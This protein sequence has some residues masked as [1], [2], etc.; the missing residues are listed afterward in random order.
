MKLP[1]C[2]HHETALMITQHLFRWWLDAVGQKAFDW[3]IADQLLCRHMARQGTIYFFHNTT[4]NFQLRLRIKWWLEKH[5]PII[6]KLILTNHHWDTIEYNQLLLQFCQNSNAYITLKKM[7]LNYYFSWF[8]S[9]LL[10]WKMVPEYA[11]IMTNKTV[12]SVLFCGNALWPVVASCKAVVLKLMALIILPNQR[13][14]GNC[15]IVTVKVTG[16]LL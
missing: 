14:R 16:L 4:Y 11:S 13:R 1:S 7:H 9:L 15:C 12:S 8:Q 5:R 10:W 3:T 6:Y 2:E